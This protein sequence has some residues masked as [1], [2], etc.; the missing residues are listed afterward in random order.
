MPKMRA[1]LKVLNVAEHGYQK[2]GEAFV[3]SSER[4]HFTAVSKPAGYP[5]DGLDDDN[6]FAKWSPTA[7]F[8]ILVTNPALFD[9]F[10]VG[11]KYYVDF[12]LA[13]E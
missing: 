10:K 2:E 3:K 4:L 13:D 6:T 1:K 11:E 5:A 7:D 9:Q 8:T 12:S